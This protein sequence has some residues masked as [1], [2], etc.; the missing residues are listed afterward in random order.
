MIC[1]AAWTFQVPVTAIQL[2]LRIRRV[3]RR[4]DARQARTLISYVAR[5]HAGGE[6]PAGGFGNC[7]RDA[8][9]G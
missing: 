3:R 6:P 2:G 4:V 8:L 5:Y 7:S 1:N 9:I